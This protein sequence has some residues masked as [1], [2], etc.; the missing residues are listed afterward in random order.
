MTN[1]I[2]RFRDKFGDLWWWSMLLFLAARS[3]DLVQ[4]FIGLWL[5]PKYVPQEE[6]GAALPLLQAGS[7]F[8]LPLAI[9]VVPF[10]RWLTIYAANGEKGKVKRLLSIA[11]CG[12]ALTFILAALASRFILPA[13]F[14]RLSVADGSLGI[15]IVCAGLLVPF[16]GVFNNALQGLKRYGAMAVCHAIAT[17]FRLVVMLVSMPFRALSG[18]ILGQMAAPAMT[19]AVSCISLRKELGR[20][21][22]SAPLGRADV[23]AMAAYTLPI[24]IYV[25]LGTLLGAWQILLFRQRLPEIESAAYYI[26]SRLGEITAYAALAIS[27]VVFPMAVEASQKGQGEGSLLAK[28]LL[29][30][31]AAGLAVTLVLAVSGRWFL[32]L[33]PLWRD[34][35]PYSG[36][37]V[38]N[39]LRMAICAANGTFY[40]CQTAAGRFKFLWYWVPLT[41][42][43]NGALVVLTGYGAF[44]GILPDAAVDWMASLDAG[45]LS[46]FI[47]W[48]LGCAAVQA[49]AVALHV[50]AMRKKA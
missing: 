49:C 12:T 13:L 31:Y 40:T 7:V 37:L 20:D 42:V 24:G 23:K 11:F 28:V 8:G 21:V 33:V 30:S 16:S 38:L 39:A 5:V 2:L 47:W 50:F 48:L 32:G 3:G 35:I 14:E 4:A 10:S 36:L 6:L 19:V 46:F 29:G 34:Y 9:L 44:R 27:A 45:R 15:L 26:I 25:A 43:E 1:L 17:P 18:Y 22:K 41:L